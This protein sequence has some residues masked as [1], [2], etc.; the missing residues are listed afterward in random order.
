MGTRDKFSILHD[1][2]VDKSKLSLGLARPFSNPFSHGSRGKVFFSPDNAFI[3]ELL[4]DA[5]W[6]V[7]KLVITTLDDAV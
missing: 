2:H 6:F 7:L 3:G 5:V 1:E 4:F